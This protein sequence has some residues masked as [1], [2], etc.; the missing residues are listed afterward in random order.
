[1][2]S[3][4]RQLRLHIEKYKLDADRCNSNTIKRWIM[5]MKV[6]DKK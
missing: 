3:N 4:I 5:N 2:N 6:I 1:M